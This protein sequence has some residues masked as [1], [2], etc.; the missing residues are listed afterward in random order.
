M[1][2]KPKYSTS[3]RLAFEAAI[4]NAFDAFQETMMNSGYTCATERV[5]ANVWE[6]ARAF[7]TGPQAT[8]PRY[9]GRPKLRLVQG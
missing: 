9:T 3:E 8:P 4:D 1:K 7:Y 2:R 6:Q 5:L